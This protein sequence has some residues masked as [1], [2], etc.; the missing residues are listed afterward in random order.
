MHL[1]KAI[2]AL[3]LA[4]LHQVSAQIDVNDSL[5]IYQDSASA[6]HRLEISDDPF[7]KTLDELFKL[8][9]FRTTQRWEERNEY[10]A[11]FSSIPDSLFE[12]RLRKLDH[13]TPLQLTYNREVRQ[14]I[15]MYLRKHQLVSRMM[16]L[17][18]L[19]FPI[20]EEVFDK[21]NIPLEIKY[22]AMVESALNPRATSV[23]G[24][25]GLWQFIYSTGRLMGL[26]ITSYIDERNDPYKSTEAAARF[27]KQLYRWFNDWNLALAAYNS[28]PGNVTKAIRRSGGKTNYWELRPYLP[29]ET[30]G[31]V[32]AFIAVNYVINYA[33]EHGIYPLEPAITFYDLDTV[34]VREPV[35]L[36]HLAEVL[37]MPAEMIS[38]LNPQYRHY[39]IPSSEDNLY[40]I[41]LPRDKW[42]LF[43]AN[44][45]TIYTYLKET[46]RSST[47]IA[48]RL[49]ANA[50][51]SPLTSGD[52]VV[53]TVKRGESLGAIA[54]K[55]K[56]NISDIKRWNNLRSN[57]IHPNQRLTIYR[58]RQG[59]SASNALAS[60]SSLKEQI[61]VI[62]HNSGTTKNYNSRNNVQYYTVNPGDTLYS[63]ARRYQGVRV[64][65]LMAWNNL[66]D[67]RDLKS[68]MK[69]KIY[70]N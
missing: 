56:V 10:T 29:R 41:A 60:A 21:H 44:E 68:G 12:Y 57:N 42:G 46:T 20:F 69:L 61:P 27:L 23:A 18:Q 7:A 67:A 26:S 6:S 34:V 24:A 2:L 4:V 58:N 54:K 33:H 40:F 50:E 48:N 59:P 38:F 25:Q 47:E 32:P 8:N 11:D 52:R 15:E 17:S 49:R 19:Y 13:K 39:I 66:K 28:G 64:E 43:V 16:G 22:L 36:R 62:R 63:I 55:Y 65:D 9:L 5:V 14:Y 31:Y 70:L 35:D 3:T 45:D 51:A 1:K 37:E 30:A 53:H